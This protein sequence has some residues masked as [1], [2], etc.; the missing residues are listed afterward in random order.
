M[1]CLK[2]KI[3]GGLLGVA[4]LFAA[5][6]AN[7]ST[8]FID[9]ASLTVAE[10]STFSLTIKGINFPNVVDPFFDP[11]D[12]FGPPTAA[13]GV[14]AGAVAL[15]WNSGII[16]FN[17]IQMLGGFSLLPGTTLTTNSLNFSADQAFG[18]GAGTAFD[19]A[20]ITFNALAAPGSNIDINVGS[21]GNW[22]LADFS[23]V[24]A[25]DVTYIGT[26]LVITSN[27]VVPVPAAAWLFASGLL[28]MV[29]VAR[30]KA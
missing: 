22:Q 19:F 25:G 15:G 14:T 2:F 10:G 27:A 29:G 1:K 5:N 13:S 20:K 6:V 7:A 30:R 8:I 26:S 28:G 11:N 9:P 16:S 23:E 18:V 17:S 3:M 21:L 12:P 24:A 4:S